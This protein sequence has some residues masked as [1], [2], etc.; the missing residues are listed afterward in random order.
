MVLRIINATEAKP[1]VIILADGEAWQVISNDISKSGKHGASKC[2]IMTSGVF[3]GK[4]KII[5]CPGSE[6]F[7]VPN[8]EKKR[9]QVLSVGETTVSAMDLETYETVDLAF[10][11]ELKEQLAPEKQVE[12]WDVEG[13]KV[14]M[15]VLN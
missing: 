8:V 7:D 5:T 9:F 1:G 4:K 13:K 11:E 2:R 14:V 12:C 15:R 10:A 3:N 6:R